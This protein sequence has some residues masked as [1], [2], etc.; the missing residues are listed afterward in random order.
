MKQLRQ[1]TI[2]SGIVRIAAQGV[3]FLLR[4]SVLMILARLLNPKDFGIVGMVT[5][6]TGIL[7]LFKDA[8]LSMVTI[9]R[10]TITNEE[11][12]SLFWMNL[13]LG[14]LLALLSCGLAPIL[15]AFYHE[16]ALFGVTIVLGLA[17]VFNAAGVQHSAILQR[18]MRF[19][20]LSIIE[21][22]SLAIA[23]ALGIILAC[24]GFQYWALAAVAVIQPA[25]ATTMTWGVTAWVPVGPRLCTY[26]PSMIRFGVTATLNG[27][28][29][30]V[31]YNLEKVL[32]GRF[33]GAEALGIYGRAFQLVSI[34]TENLN[35]ATGN[36]LFSAL[37]RLQNDPRRLRMYFL[38]MY[39]A[40]VA[41]T[42]PCTLAFVLFANDI[43]IFVLGE[44]WHDVVPIF[45]LL[46]PT[47]LV[48]GLINPLYWMV[49]SIGMPGRSLKIA[50]VLAPIVIASYLLALP[51]GP[52]A[53]ALAYSLA[54]MLSLIPCL[55][56]CTHGTVFSV[57]DLLVTV[58]P[59]L[60]SSFVAAIA[61]YL[62]GQLFLQP[63]TLAVRLVFECG[64]FLS[65]YLWMLLFIMKQKEAYFEIFQG[66][67][68]W[69]SYGKATA[70]GYDT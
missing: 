22:L 29:M 17:I 6:V 31:A 36:V 60:V 12:S 34:P 66:I 68:V 2:Q 8:G 11:V 43:I 48:F 59:P 16:P 67:D 23:S 10:E 37:S 42:L 13:G 1:L 57:S 45:R 50:L 62:M 51:Y 14:V 5:A 54:M 46:T 28:V 19:G 35:S 3:T 32:L 52:Q 20:V 25:L 65:I 70:K 9:Q 24:Y 53:V 26:V 56:W 39:G 4:V 41:L 21:V 18:E 58:L 61:V 44:K 7:G 69:S 33:W 49:I 63:L 64:A 30:Y 27:V 55:M 38:K 47:V 15:A 40:L